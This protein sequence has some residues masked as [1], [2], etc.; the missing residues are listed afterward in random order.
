MSVQVNMQV[1]G[2]HWMDD[3]YYVRLTNPQQYEGQVS[4]LGFHAPSMKGKDHSMEH[5]THVCQPPEETTDKRVMEG[6]AYNKEA[7]HPSGFQTRSSSHYQ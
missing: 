3:M 1:I 7:L 5:S 4:S 2:T 6:Y